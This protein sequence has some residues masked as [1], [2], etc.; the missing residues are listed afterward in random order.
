MTR[1]TLT[2]EFL[3]YLRRHR[4]AVYAAIQRNRVTACDVEFAAHSGRCSLIL[5]GLRDYPP[6]V[7]DR[8]LGHDA[9]CL[10]LD[11]PPSLLETSPRPADAQ[12]VLAVS[13]GETFFVDTHLLANLRG[14][15]PTEF[16]ERVVVARVTDQVAYM[17]KVQVG[18]HEI[19]WDLDELRC[20]CRDL[21]WRV[22]AAAV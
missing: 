16:P 22:P 9:P 21:A 19:N 4:P 1:Y 7:F 11:G 17:L 13:V 6:N 8:Q 10:V 20:G 3:A 12:P 15:P 2:P 18:A 5:A 14:W